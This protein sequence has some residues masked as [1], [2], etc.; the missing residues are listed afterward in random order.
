MKSRRSLRLVLFATV[1]VGGLVADLATKSW[2]FGRLG[3][4]GAEAPIWLV[5]P[6]FSL[7]TSLN[8]GALWGLGQG[9]TILFVLLSFAALGVI[10]GVLFWGDGVKNL[11]LT[12][13]LAC[14]TA[15]VLGNLF[16]R[17]GLPGLEWNDAQRWGDPVYAVRDWLHFEIPGVLDW[18]VF[19][20]ADSL[21][22]IGAGVI[23]A[24]S[25]LHDLSAWQRAKRAGDAGSLSDAASTKSS[26]PN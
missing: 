11:P 10:M 7:T 21:L 14:I 17:L 25:V 23:V 3:M 6:Y 4:P 12:L 15:G 9:M 22:V 13:A 24:M 20:L 5:P 16:D 8:E 18:P 2:I 26:A 19:N 1:A